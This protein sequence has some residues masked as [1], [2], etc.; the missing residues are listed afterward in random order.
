MLFQVTL[1]AVRHSTYISWPRKVLEAILFENPY[2][3]AIMTNLIGRDI[4]NKL[5]ILNQQAKNPSIP[6]KHS[7]KELRSIWSDASKTHLNSA[8]LKKPETGSLTALREMRSTERQNTFGDS[9]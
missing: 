9:S 7:A 8:G 3:N 1:T 2:L 6:S 5:Y 4:T